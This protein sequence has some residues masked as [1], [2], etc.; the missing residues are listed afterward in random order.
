MV[1]TTTR[2]TSGFVQNLYDCLAV[3]DE[4]VAFPAETLEDAAVQATVAYYRVEGL[5]PDREEDA[6]DIRDIR[7][8]LA[9]IILAI[10]KVSALD[11]DQLGMGEKAGLCARYTPGGSVAA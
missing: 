4:I 7:A 3:Q 9:S 6:S 8:L 2:C 1:P 10:V 11:I 5:T